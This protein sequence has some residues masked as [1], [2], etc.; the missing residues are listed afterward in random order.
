[1]AFKLS[2]SAIAYPRGTVTSQDF[3]KTS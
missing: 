3:V 1:V 2:H